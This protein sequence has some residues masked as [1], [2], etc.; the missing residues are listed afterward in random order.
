MNT[1][2][3]NTLETLGAVER[4]ALLDQ[5]TLERLA[6]EGYI[7]VSDVTGHG[8]RELLFISL[9]AKGARLLASFG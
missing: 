1:S 5:S 9:T 4:G 2:L 3:T 8:Q 7:E 6:A